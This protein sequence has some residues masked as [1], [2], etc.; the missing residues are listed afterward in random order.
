MVAAIDVRGLSFRYRGSSAW[1]LRDVDFRVSV[2]EAVLVTGPTGSGKSTLLR[3][4][5]GLLLDFYEGEA[6]GT[7]R[8]LG[9]DVLDLRP[10]RVA[11][12]VGTVF[13]SPEDQMIASNVRRDVAF[14][15]E[16]LGLSREIIEARV[17]EALETVGLRDLK[18]REALKLSGGQMQRLA[19]ASVVAM[20]PRVL[21]LD[22]PASEVDPLGRR[23]I[24]RAVKGLARNRE[25]TVVLTD[26][27]LADVLGIVDRLVVLDAG[28]VL[29]DGP[30]RDVMARP[31][32]E[33]WGVE[34]PK[35]IQVWRRL[36]SEGY[37]APCPLTQEELVDGLIRYGRTRPDGL[38]AP[39]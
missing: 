23:G 5:N 9:E 22:E 25:R 3:A 7:A 26:H 2:G 18:D 27:R 16:N 32:L 28:R 37:G 19:L 17:D 30:P 10:N 33:G 12:F 31:E 14:G 1:A 20:R 15:L 35:P 4:I 39:A 21:L 6:R 24:L 34:V 13:Q 36:A 11:T 38:E 29:L 8:V